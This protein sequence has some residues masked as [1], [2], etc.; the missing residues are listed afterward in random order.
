[1][2]NNRDSCAFPQ[3]GP[4]CETASG[5]LDATDQPDTV[6]VVALSEWRAALA[7]SVSPALQH[8]LEAF[9]HH[10]PDGIRG[11][12]LPSDH[13]LLRMAVQA[14]QLQ[15]QN[16]SFAAEAV[17]SGILAATEAA[18]GARAR[19][20]GGRPRRIPPELALLARERLKALIA[21]G[22]L[23]HPRKG[24]RAQ[25]IEFFADEGL[26]LPETYTGQHS[27]IDYDVILPVEAELRR[28]SN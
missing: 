21:A 20:R 28:S 15:Q 6:D 16:A 17:I 7:V 1:M 11:Y 18:D 2:L 19:N 4:V 27:P 9:H 13:P 26:S 23:L 22:L 12:L 14:T 5:I 8:F 10:P 3:I 25:M 24:V